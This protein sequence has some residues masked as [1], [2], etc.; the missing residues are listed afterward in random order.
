VYFSTKLG[1]LI[2]PLLFGLIHLSLP[3]PQVSLSLLQALLFTDL[4]IDILE[5]ETRKPRNENF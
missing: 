5:K 1:E 4:R 2:T 3:Q